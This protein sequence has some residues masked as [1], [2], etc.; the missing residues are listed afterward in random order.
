M[1]GRSAKP[2]PFVVLLLLLI[3]SRAYASDNLW[4][5]YLLAKANDPTTGRSE[6]RLAASRAE[7]HIVFSGLIPHLDA[8]AG[9]NRID[10]TLINYVP[11][12]LNSSFTAHNYSIVARLPLLHVPTLYNIAAAYA[13]VRSGEA[14]VSAARQ[15]LIAKVVDSYFGLLKAKQD[16][17]IAKDEIGRL[18]QILEQSQAFLKAGTGDIIAVYEA[19]ARLDSVTADLA[20]SESV[21]RIAELKLSAIVGKPVQSVSDY[22]P[23]QAR[24]PDPD[25]LDWWLSAMDKQEPQII[26]AREGMSQAAAQLSAAKAEFLPVIQAS[27]G[28]NDSV[29]SAFLPEVETRQWYVGATVSLPLFSGGETAAKIRRAKAAESERKYMLEE[30]RDQ[31]RENL[32]QAFF[33]LRHNVNMIKALER[34]KSSA[35]LQLT[36]I[37]KGRSIGTRTATDLINAEQSYSMAVRDLRNAL[38]DNTVKQVQL[39]AAAGILTEDDI[40]EL[41]E[42]ADPHPPA[43]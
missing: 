26:Q 30:L 28:Y 37:R 20:R 19:Q 42:T 2:L 7:S 16:L 29:G 18:N 25:N 15:K 17:E 41:K 4:E 14:G 23:K 36:A 39:K 43:Q 12:P 9:I 40:A 5:L 21:L 11:Q 8:S 32:K 34:K 27:G 24:L 33:N 31:L 10:H 6:S 3:I 13:G 22:L 38:Y 1:P 35:E